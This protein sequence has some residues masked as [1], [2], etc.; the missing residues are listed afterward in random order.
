MT[1]S[2]VIP[3]ALYD[4]QFCTCVEQG[5]VEK[6]DEGVEIAVKFPCDGCEFEAR[7]E[8]GLERHKHVKHARF[9]WCK[10]CG[11]EW[12]G[13]DVREHEEEK[14]KGEECL[15]GGPDDVLAI[16]KLEAEARNQCKRDLEE[17][18]GATV[19]GANFEAGGQQS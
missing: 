8:A 10:V 17:M 9:V 13:H 7:T 19:A 3:S 11:E 1:D 14:H 12:Y 4:H 16:L 15:S 6:T 5:A 2:V 18:A